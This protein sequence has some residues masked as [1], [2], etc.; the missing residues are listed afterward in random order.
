MLPLQQPDVLG[1]DL[2]HVGLVVVEVERRDHLPLVDMLQRNTSLRQVLDVTEEWLEVQ[3][4]H[5]LC[6]QLVLIADSHAS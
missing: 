3:Y 1:Q 2:Y 5:L 4:V 6:F